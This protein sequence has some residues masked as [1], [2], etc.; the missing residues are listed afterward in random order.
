MIY[1]LPFRGEKKSS[2]WLL[3]LLHRTKKK[4]SL[5][6]TVEDNCLFE[7]HFDCMYLIQAD[8]IYSFKCI[9]SVFKCVHFQFGCALY[10]Q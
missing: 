2:S 7:M 1:G 9:L 6:A 5:S 3:A 4:N 8:F 10:Q